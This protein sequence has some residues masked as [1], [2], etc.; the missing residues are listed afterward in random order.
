MGNAAQRGKSRCRENLCSGDDTLSQEY[1]VYFKKEGLN[2]GANYPVDAAAVLCGI[3]LKQKSSF[4]ICEAAQ[5][6][7]V[8]GTYAQPADSREKRLK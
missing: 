5:I 3:A 2:R 6:Q 7:H 1:F 8:F 4:A